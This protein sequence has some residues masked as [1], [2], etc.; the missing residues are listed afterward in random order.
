MFNHYF[1]DLGCSI[2]EVAI[3]NFSISI[4]WSQA[5]P[6]FF[7]TGR[8]ASFNMTDCYAYDGTISTGKDASGLAMTNYNPAGGTVERCY[9]STSITGGQ[10]GYI[11]P[12]FGCYDENGLVLNRSYMYYNGNLSN[13][14][15]RSGGTALSTFGNMTSLPTGF[16]SNIWALIDDNGDGN[17]DR[18]ELKIFMTQAQIDAFEN[19]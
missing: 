8:G 15:N 1:L 2:N 14:Y 5:A 16:S 18:P 12:I 17:F 11:F 10:R 9:C 13:T 6:L 7:L 19:P 3:T 4:Y